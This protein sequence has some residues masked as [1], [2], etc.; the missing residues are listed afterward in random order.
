MTLTTGTVD[1]P[2]L[3]SEIMDTKAYNFIRAEAERLHLPAHYTD[4]LY[5]HDRATLCGA[6]GDPIPERSAGFSI[7]P[8]RD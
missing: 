2:A 5:L 1:R 4:D 8:A 7:P 6:Y 3:V